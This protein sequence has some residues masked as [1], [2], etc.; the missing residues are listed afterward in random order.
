MACY[1]Q[2]RHEYSCISPRTFSRSH[3]LPKIQRLY[4]IERKPL[5]VP[6]MVQ[7]VQANAD[8]N[9]DALG[10]LPAQA[11]EQAA[12][13]G[14]LFVAVNR[15]GQECQYAGHILFGASYPH[16]RIFQVYVAAEHR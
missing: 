11:Y 5:E 2:I 16:A 7:S 13:Q 10:F 8:S 4:E 1:P 15:R 6:G 12:R 3:C 14:T 9:R